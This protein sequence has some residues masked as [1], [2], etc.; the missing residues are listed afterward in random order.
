M[1]DWGVVAQLVTVLQSLPDVAR[2]LWRQARSKAE[3][4]SFRAEA[5][6]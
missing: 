3:A 6:G 4:S 5:F 2:P 1:P